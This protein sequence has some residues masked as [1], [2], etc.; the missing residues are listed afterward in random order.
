MELDLSEEKPDTDLKELMAVLRRE[1]KLELEE[2]N[3]EILAFVRSLGG[4]SKKY[5]RERHRA[6]K[7][8]VSE[9]YSPPCVTAVSN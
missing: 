2:A 4:D 5:S 8:V 7:A 9:M 3:R 1:D 6:A